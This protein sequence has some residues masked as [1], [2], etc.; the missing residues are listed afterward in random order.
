MVKTVGL[1]ASRVAP[2]VRLVHHKGERRRL[3]DEDRRRPSRLVDLSMEFGFVALQKLVEHVAAL[4]YGPVE[5]LVMQRLLRAPRVPG[6]RGSF[7]LVLQTD[8][9]VADALNLERAFVGRVLAE[10][11]RDRMVYSETLKGEA[12]QGGAPRDTSVVAWGID[13]GAFV[14]VVLY[15]LDH[16]QRRLEAAPARHEAAFVCPSCGFEINETDLGSVSWSSDGDLMCPRGKC[17][18]AVMQEKEAPRTRSSEADAYLKSALRAQTSQLHKL[19]HDAS[20]AHAPA[21]CWPGAE[22]AP[23]AAGESAGSSLEDGASEPVAAGGALAEEDDEEQRRFREEYERNIAG[24]DLQAFP[25]ASVDPP[26]APEAQ[27]CV[28]D[29]ESLED[30]EVEVQGTKKMLSEITEEDQENMTSA[31]YDAF[32][33]L[34]RE[35]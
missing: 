22:R 6:P 23:E 13:F 35:E 15:K 25:E 20:D 31:E 28:D 16:M 12:A 17:V 32:W 4:F 27:P 2:V 10:L 26:Q 33:R 30:V 3:R 8:D 29:D 1:H 34:L 11:R 5:L 21:Y 18:G 14:D 7:S 24:A 9:A 19:L